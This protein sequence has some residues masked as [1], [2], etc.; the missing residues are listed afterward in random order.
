MSRQYEELCESLAS[1]LES[2][3][4]DSVALLQQVEQL[5]SVSNHDHNNIISPTKLILWTGLLWLYFFP[6]ESI[7]SG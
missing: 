5:K 1:M 6:A 7:E 2:Q 4:N 3:T